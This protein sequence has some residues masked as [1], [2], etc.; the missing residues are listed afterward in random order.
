VFRYEGCIGERSIGK[1]A[2]S[3][4]GRILCTVRFFLIASF[5]RLFSFAAYFIDRARFIPFAAH[6]NLS[7][8]RRANRTRPELW[9]S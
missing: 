4:N 8:N 1:I 5:A 3:R 6:R 2:G 7:R 9:A